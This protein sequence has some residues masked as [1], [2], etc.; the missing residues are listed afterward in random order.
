MRSLVHKILWAAPAGLITLGLAAA[1]IWSGV[2]DW[3]AEQAVLG[4][5]AAMGSPPILMAALAAV[6]IYVWALTWTAKEKTSAAPTRN[7]TVQTERPWCESYWV[8]AGD[9]KHTGFFLNRFYLVVS[10]CN[11][12]GQVIEDC[13]VYIQHL[14]PATRCI[15]RG[16]ERDCVSIRHGEYVL[17]AIGEM[18]APSPAGFLHGDHQVKDVKLHNVR[19]RSYEFFYP[20]SGPGPAAA[21]HSPGH[22]WKMSLVVTGR[23][24]VS[25]TIHMDVC[26][27]NLLDPISLSLPSKDETWW[28]RIL[29]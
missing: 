5:T 10:N 14:R 12:D 6:A 28:R 24:L 25:Q 17:F 23:G 1:G 9:G 3:M 26:M 19:N 4:W 21:A 13:S 16:D 18:M 15:T 27:D 7:I 22:V 29:P 20:S 8:E 11:P 2:R